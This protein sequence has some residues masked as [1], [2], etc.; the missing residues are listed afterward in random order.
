MKKIPIWKNIVLIVS[1]LVVIVIATLAWFV[2]EN[3]GEVTAMDVD[4]KGA[5]FI[6]IS[7]DDG[8]SW[9]EDLDLEIGLNDRIKEISGDGTTFYEPTYDIAQTP[10]GDL[11][12]II[13]TFE[14]VNGPEKYYEQIVSF[15]ADANHDVYLAPTSYVSAVSG[16]ENSY[17]AGAIRVAFFELDENDNE[18]L[19]CIWAPN[20]TIEYSAQ[21]NSFTKEGTVEPNYYYQISKTPVDVNT[22]TDD[23]SNPHVQKI[24]TADPENTDDIPV[25]GYDP[26]HKFMWSSG[27]E[28]PE[29]APSLLTLQLA[30][31][32]TLGN[33][34]MKIK[35]WLEGHD[36]ECVSLLAG[37][38]FTMK[39]E[40]TATKGE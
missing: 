26:L 8:E 35:V 31:G 15:R 40:F 34:R 14:Q 38:K 28:L 20:S 7:S 6:Q 37:Q 5:S 19:K 4:V 21:T 22:L 29:N 27:E 9:M 10:D 36:R 1:A 17:I 25:C 12:P 33:K 13:S 32:D 16:E 23:V 24:P 11:V 30:D 3:W 39:F 2:T 18:T